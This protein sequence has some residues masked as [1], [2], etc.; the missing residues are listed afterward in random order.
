VNAFNSEAF[1]S[2]DVTDRPQ[3]EEEVKA[4]EN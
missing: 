1:F 4:L 2:N 3:S